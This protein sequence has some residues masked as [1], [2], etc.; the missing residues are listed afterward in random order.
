MQNPLHKKPPATARG[1]L[2][3]PYSERE[4]TILLEIHHL[5]DPAVA[6]SLEIMDKSPG[7]DTDK[8]MG[9]KPTPF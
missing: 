2:P 8:D 4:S 9:H 5:D 3:L 7:C 1:V 6:P